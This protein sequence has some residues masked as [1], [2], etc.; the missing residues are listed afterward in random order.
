MA[1]SEAIW[2]VMW[3]QQKASHQT[4]THCVCRVFFVKI[5]CETRGRHRRMPPKYTTDKDSTQQ[6][7]TFI[8]RKNVWMSVKRLQRQTAVQVERMLHEIDIGTIQTHQITDCWAM[9]HKSTLKALVPQS[10]P[11]RSQ[12]APSET[13][14]TTFHN[15]ANTTFLKPKNFPDLVKKIK[16]RRWGELSK[17]LV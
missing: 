11:W 2:T 13:S 14:M 6:T 16:T 7:E 17:W 8:L 4:F 9:L 5:G 15:H 3:L 10:T 1:C 12:Y